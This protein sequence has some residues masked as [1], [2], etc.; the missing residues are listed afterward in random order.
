MPRTKN[1]TCSVEDC[2]NKPVAKTYCP[3]HYKRW[4][5]WGDPNV[6]TYKRRHVTAYGYI[7]IPDPHKRK[8]SILEHRLVMEQ[9][10]G[11]FLKKGENVHHRNG[12]K[13]DNR[14]E[15]LELWNTIQ[16][17]GQRIEDK[18]E[19]AVEILETYAPHLLKESN[20]D[21]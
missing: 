13:H 8:K 18:I 11:R 12:I 2:T 1:I 15:N 5:K 6:V 10:L 20:N 9:H 14:I 17:K 16:P 19:Y 4:L 3:K 7:R 21:K